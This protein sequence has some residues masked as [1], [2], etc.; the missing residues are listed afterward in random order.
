MADLNKNK[1]LS[2][3]ELSNLETSLKPF[4]QD[5]KC[6]E[7]RDALLIMLILKTGARAQEALNV[8]KADLNPEDKTVLIRGIKNSKDREIPLPPHFFAK[9][10]A[11]VEHG[12]NEQRVFLISYQRLFQLWDRY[13]TA[14]KGIHSLR[15]TFALNLYKKTKDIN[16]VKQALGHRSIN[17]TLIYQSYAYSTS[18]LRKALR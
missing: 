12:E 9:L 8:T 16:I 10:W 11:F 2:E 7:H 6:D 13:R 3:S 15:H 1:F 18:E 14:K 17:S 5:D 4:W